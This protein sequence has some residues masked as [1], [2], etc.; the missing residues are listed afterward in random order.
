MT[1]NAKPKPLALETRS[2]EGMLI[3]GYKGV[4]SKEFDEGC[5]GC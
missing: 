2:L 1:D 5:S 3:L 4:L